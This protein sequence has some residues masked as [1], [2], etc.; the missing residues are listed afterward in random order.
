M[1]AE[2]L[3]DYIMGWFQ[4]ATDLVS[5]GFHPTGSEHRP[6]GAATGSQS[7]V[8]AVAQ[9]AVVYK[10]QIKLASWLQR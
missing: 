4:D 9:P 8:P 5:G 10:S 2:F 3:L 1:Q 6:G 7:S